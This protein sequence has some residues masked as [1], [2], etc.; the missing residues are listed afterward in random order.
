MGQKMGALIDRTPKY[1]PE[2][3]G[4]GI[5]YCWGCTRK[6]Y[7]CLLL[8][9]KRKKEKFMGSMRKSLSREVLHQEQTRKLVQE[10]PMYT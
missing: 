7:R 10:S 6:Y 8:E 1:H 5:G 3:A 9:G 4:E 2:L